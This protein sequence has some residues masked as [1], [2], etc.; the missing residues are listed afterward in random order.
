MFPQRN[1]LLI[2]ASLI[3]DYSLPVSSPDKPLMPRHAWQP[4]TPR[5]VAAFAGATLTRLVL[6]QSIV[7]VIVAVALLWFLRIAWFPVITESIQRLPQAGVIRRGE[8]QYGGESPG[9]LA[10]N[11]R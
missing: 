3:T 2:T 5:G 4:F 6:V 1:F 8:L 9:R 10:A 7:A 11:S